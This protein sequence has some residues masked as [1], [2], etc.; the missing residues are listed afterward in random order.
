M[1]VG[2]RG[3]ENSKSPSRTSEASPGS[4]RPAARIKSRPY[5]PWLLP[6]GR[7][8][9]LVREDWRS[10]NLACG[11][12][13]PVFEDQSAK[14]EARNHAVE[15]DCQA[16]QLR[17]LSRTSEASPGSLL[18][19]AARIKSRPYS[20]WL[21]PEGRRSELVREDWHSHNLACGHKT[22]V[23]EDQSAKRATMPLRSIARR[24]S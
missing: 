23:F 6:E 13:T 10:H 4:L 2:C 19:P 16:W 20:P 17:Q 8:S 1:W 22:P 15:V 14:R 12:K 9:E 21:L 11:H 24:G 7:R 3:G 5:S 18:R